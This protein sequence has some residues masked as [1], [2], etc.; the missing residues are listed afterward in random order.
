MDLIFTKISEGGLSFKFDIFESNLLNLLILVGGLV[1]LLNASLSKALLDRKEKI[2]S[3]IQE[4]EEKLK[5]A[6]TRLVESETK[7]V[8]V[9]TVLNE[10][11][12]ESSRIIEQNKNRILSDGNKEKKRIEINTTAQIRR[13]LDRVCR[14][15]VEYLKK[16][17][18]GVTR[19]EFCKF[20]VIDQADRARDRDHL[21]YR[22]VFMS[23]FATFSCSPLERLS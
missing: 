6:T 12:E 19:R 13:I 4:S 23:I 20:S 7:L 16:F 22:F 2:L 10:I 15:I 14:Q 17:L 11:Q 1:R 18:M 9:E 8:Q 21:R 5:E 3:T